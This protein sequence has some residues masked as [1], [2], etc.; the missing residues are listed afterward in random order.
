MSGEVEFRV[1][2]E[3]GI[4]VCRLLD[5]AE[6]AKNRIEKYT[7]ISFRHWSINYLISDVF[8]G[9]AK[10]APEDTFDEEV[11]KKIALTKAKAKRCKAV[12]YMIKKFIEDEKRDLAVLA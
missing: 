1:F 5:C 9:I 2:P 8:V 10:C 3:K 6:I 7:H 12:N 4:V 11:G